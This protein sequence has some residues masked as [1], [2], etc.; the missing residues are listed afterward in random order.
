MN[1][2]GCCHHCYH[3]DRPYIW[4]VR[5]MF[6]RICL[7]SDDPLIGSSSRHHVT[8]ACSLHPVNDITI[9]HKIYFILFRCNS[10][11]YPNIICNW[12]KT[13][14]WFNWRLWTIIWIR[15]CWWWRRCCAIRVAI[16]WTTI[17]VI[18]HVTWFTWGKWTS[19]KEHIF[20]W[21][22]LKKN[23]YCKIT[24][25]V[26]CQRNHWIGYLWSMSPS[27]AQYHVDHSRH[28]SKQLIG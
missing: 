25:C 17:A 16:V 27:M 9:N 12:L 22:N 3:Q 14:E 24:L 28:C 20:V 11:T 6:D 7:D 23:V 1:W 19:V 26:G 13:S 2:G 4:I 21:I 5:W 18:I 15:P 8:V 10:M